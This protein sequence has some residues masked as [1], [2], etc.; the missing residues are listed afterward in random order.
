MVRCQNVQEAAAQAIN[1]TG[2]RIFVMSPIGVGS[3]NAYLNELA[4]YAKKDEIDLSVFAALT[5]ERPRLPDSASAGL[6]NSIYERINRGYTT[7]SYFDECAEAVRLG[8]PVPRY[9]TYHSYYYTPGLGGRVPGL[10]ADYTAVNFRDA[11]ECARMRGL[12]M[13]VMKASRRGGKY[14]CG[15]NVD[16]M[17]R[18]IRDVKNAGGTVMLLENENMPYVYGNAEIPENCID[19]VASSNEPLYIMPH[20]PLSVIE[21]AIGHYVSELVSDGATLQIGIGQMADSIAF[22]LAKRGR[23]GLNGYSELI[24]PAFHFMVRE[25]VITRRDSNGALLTGAFIVGGAEL[26]RYVDE[27]R[28]IRMTEVHETNNKEFIMKLPKFHA[29]NSALQMDLFTQGSSEGFIVNDRYVQYTGM[30]GQFEFQESAKKSEGGKSILCLRSAYRDEDGVPRGSNIV[31]VIHNV[32]GV[33]RNKMDYVVTEYGWRQIRFAT[34]EERARAAIELADSQY[35]DELVSGARTLGLIR[36][37]YAVPE[38]FR[39]NTYQSLRDRFGGIAAAHR[40][41][42]GLGFDPK[43]YATEEE[44]ALLDREDDVS[45]PGKK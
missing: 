14:N 35:Q 36:G 26:Y 40:Y 15:T 37:S 8:A 44:R 32:V 30:G 23:T 1:K 39:N 19:F 21:H 24:S 9:L 43:E 27:N 16:I 10:Q 31:P 25:G 17:L 4:G 6:R 41:P 45:G 42:L 7:F 20:Q 12:N 29:V 33:T 38:E 22:W 28:D 2:R 5:L 3:G 11:N 34:I 13:V 18:A